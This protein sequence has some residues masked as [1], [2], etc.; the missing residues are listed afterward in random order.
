MPRRVIYTSEALNKR[1]VARAAVTGVSVSQLACVLLDQA[2]S[3]Y[4]LTAPATSAEELSGQGKAIADTVV[5]NILGRGVLEIPDG[6][7]PPT[8]GP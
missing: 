7:G 4:D 8:G 2:L 5:G 1:L 6:S 3:L